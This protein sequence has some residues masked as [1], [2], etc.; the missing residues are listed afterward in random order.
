MKHEAHNDEI[1]N[2]DDQG[3]AVS[4]ITSAKQAHGIFKRMKTHYESTARD[5][6]KIQGLIDGN[7][8]YSESALR[9]MGQ[10]WRSNVNFREAEAEI[11]K[12]VNMY[13]QL[14]MEVVKLINVQIKVSVIKKNNIL[15]ADEWQEIIAEEYSNTLRS[16]AGFF[17]NVSL[18]A[19]EMLKY[20]LGPVMFPDTYDWK[21]EA[22][23]NASCMLP[24]KTK[25]TTEKNQFICIRD[26]MQIDEIFEILD[27]D[28]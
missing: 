18:H 4:R 24:A 20:G 28:K 17:Y 16:W 7:A 11:E 1:N 6:A 2:V 21:F 12:N 9:R 8:P 14:I 27:G 19:S 13:W 15:L 5:R 25:S 10:G 3:K 23:K 26:E 22:I